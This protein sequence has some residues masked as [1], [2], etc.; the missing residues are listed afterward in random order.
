MKRISLLFAVV[1]FCLIGET[2]KAA[3]SCKDVE[4]LD[5]A[6][7]L[8]GALEFMFRCQPISAQ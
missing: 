8:G 1:T 4:M 2:A 3:I 7:N 5:R 6:E